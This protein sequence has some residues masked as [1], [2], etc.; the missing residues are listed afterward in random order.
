MIKGRSD[1]I[2]GY[3]S[4]CLTFLFKLNDI[5]EKLEETI[6]DIGVIEQE[7]NNTLKVMQEES[8]K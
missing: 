6:R 4:S 5:K 7:I 3:K 2:E 1:N 8:E